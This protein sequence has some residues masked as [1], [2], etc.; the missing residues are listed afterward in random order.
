MRYFALLDGS[1]GAYGISFP[2]CPGCTA[3]G[4]TVDAAVANAV[5]ALAEWLEDA[6][7]TSPA[8]SEFEAFRALPEVMEAMAEGASILPVPA[9]FESERPVRANISLNR[10][11]LEAIDEAARRANLTRSGFIA[12]AAREK[13]GSLY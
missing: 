2:D 7:E 6:G 5:A 12:A 13:I 3:M 10:G 1:A 9:L 8:P 11:L 4:E